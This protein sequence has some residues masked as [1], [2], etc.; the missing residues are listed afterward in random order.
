MRA[1]YL[2][3]A[4]LLASAACAFA[5][6]P[7]EVEAEAIKTRL[8]GQTMMITWRD[9]GTLYGTFH[10]LYVAFCPSGA[11]L[12]QGGTSK[13][14]VLG[15]EQRSSFSDRGKWSVATLGQAVVLTSR[16]VSGQV[17]AFPMHLLPDG[18]LWVGDGVTMLPQ[19]PAP[20]R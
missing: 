18:R 8:S 19:G 3:A 4:L 15:N 7:P 1:N 2:G 14:T 6:M 11:Y 12:T 10:Q 20:C 5:Q 16:S 17:N 13:T 9:G